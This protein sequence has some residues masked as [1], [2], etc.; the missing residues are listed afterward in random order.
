MNN[1]S[2]NVL[3]GIIGVWNDKVLLLQR[4]K[5][6]RFMPGVWGIPAG[7]VEFGEKAEEAVL[8]E[9]REEAGITG[10]I[11]HIVGTMN[12]MSKKDG[13]IL[14]NI[15]INY[16]INLISDDVMLDTSSDNFAWISPNDI[17]SPKLDDFTRTSIQPAFKREN[18]DG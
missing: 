14:H 11:S 3:V 15:Q 10:E 16:L 7:K 13:N 18:H 12:F 6:E 1:R 2:F 4:S 8:R 9:L 5:K 17:D